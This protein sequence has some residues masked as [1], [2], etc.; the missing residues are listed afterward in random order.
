MAPKKKKITHYCAKC[1]KT[2]KYVLD[3]DKKTATCEKCQR[4]LEYRPP[5]RRR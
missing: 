3:D 4:V 2:T 5:K 1:K